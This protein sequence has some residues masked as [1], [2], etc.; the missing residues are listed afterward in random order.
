MPKQ[1]PG[2]PTY[3]IDSKGKV[4]RTVNGKTTSI[5]TNITKEGYGQVSLYKTVNGESKRFVSRIHILMKK[6]FGLKGEV[7]DHKNGSRS[8]NSLK[9]L[10]GVSYSANNKNKHGKKYPHAR[11]IYG[12]SK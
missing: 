8:N 10:K 6:A 9:N 1:I 12:K 4:T 7:I 5:K 2:F 11:E 3:Y